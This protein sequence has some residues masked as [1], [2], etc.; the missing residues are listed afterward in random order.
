ML[1]FLYD[2]HPG[3]SQN[4]SWYAGDGMRAV[5]SHDEGKTWQQEVYVLSRIYKPGAEPTG[6]GAYLGDAVE[7]AD[8]RLLTTCTGAV[9]SQNRFSAII[10]KP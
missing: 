6:A 2:G 8:G 7:L 9:G 4:V 3:K 10:W 1:Q 5:M